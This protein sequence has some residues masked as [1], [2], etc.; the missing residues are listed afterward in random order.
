VG[1]G[2][3]VVVTAFVRVKVQCDGHNDERC[4]SSFESEAAL[5]TVGTEVK[6][7]VVDE[8][9]FTH[10]E[11]WDPYAYRCPACCKKNEEEMQRYLPR[12]SRRK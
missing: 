9:S 11:G 5:M 1:V 7:L 8:S 3:G 10:P 2:E 4:H 12:S 6:R